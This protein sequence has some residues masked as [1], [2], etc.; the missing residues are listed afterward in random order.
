MNSKAIWL[1]NR[2]ELP[3]DAETIE[4]FRDQ[5]EPN[6]PEWFEAA[7][8]CLQKASAGVGAPG[9]DID[10]EVAY[11]RFWSSLTEPG[12]PLHSLGN[13]RRFPNPHIRTNGF[14]VRR[15][16]LLSFGFQLA[17]LED[18]LQPVRKRARRLTG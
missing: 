2:D 14:V 11:T 10:R 9:L 8:L 4:L 15:S 17:E 1:A 3:V 16:L 6:A 18:R 12:G 5:L 7:Q 13:Y